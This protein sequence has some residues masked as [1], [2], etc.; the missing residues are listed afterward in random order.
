M[1]VFDSAEDANAAA[2]M[3]T[4]SVAKK[5]GLTEQMV[6]DGHVFCAKPETMVLVD[7]FPDGSWEYQDVDED[8]KSITMSGTNAALLV[9]Y[10]SPEHQAAFAE[11]AGA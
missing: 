11:Q 10:L 6:D 9:L 7:V 4:V 5:N 8:G 2:V 1:A 3:D